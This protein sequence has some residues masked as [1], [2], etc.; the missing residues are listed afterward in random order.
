MGNNTNLL[1][2]AFLRNVDK[3]RAKV[4]AGP[5]PLKSEQQQQQIQ[6]YIL[7]ALLLENL[8]QRGTKKQTRE[9]FSL[10]RN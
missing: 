5:T 10:T 6:P 9:I 3:Q 4:S 7:R 8:S 1:R 2:K